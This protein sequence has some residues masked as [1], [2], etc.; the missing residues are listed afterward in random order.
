MR[1]GI[2]DSRS[3]IS[4][5]VELPGILFY[6]TVGGPWKTSEPIDKYH[7]RVEHLIE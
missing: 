6:E 3:T 5:L 7:V 4:I 2:E 1:A